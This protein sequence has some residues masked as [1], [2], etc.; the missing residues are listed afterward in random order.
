MILTGDYFPLFAVFWSTPIQA[1]IA[2]GN[3]YPTGTTVSNL[4]KCKDMCLQETSTLCLS[5]DYLDNEG[6]CLLGYAN[7]H[8]LAN[9]SHFNAPCYYPGYV[10]SERLDVGSWT[11]ETNLCIVEEEEL[12]SGAM[13]DL[14]S[15]KLVCS[16]TKSCCSIV[17][18][19][20][21]CYMN[22][23]ERISNLVVDP[24]PS[25]SCGWVYT[26]RTDVS[27]PPP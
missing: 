16:Q 8:N 15:C 19:D 5:I 27:C 3:I 26:E 13:I 11:E 22:T 12:W 18:Q 6:H 1:C 14:A 7:Q 2:D 23:F 20:G 21:R 17:F 25:F 4:Q 10:Y 9:T 24:L